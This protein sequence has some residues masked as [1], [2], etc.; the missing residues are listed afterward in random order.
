MS[1]VVMHLIQRDLKALETL[2]ADIDA[3]IRKA[4]CQQ[5]A[6]A[7]EEVEADAKYAVDLLTH[8]RD[9]S[10]EDLEVRAGYLVNDGMPTTGVLAYIQQAKQ[11]RAE[12]KAR[13]IAARKAA[14]KA[15]ETAK[16]V[17]AATGKHVDDGN[18]KLGAVAHF[19]GA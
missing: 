18:F 11:R 9:F 14:A 15:A 16:A 12:A 3:A 6:H 1:N 8:L 7:L 19:R 5:E 2:L 10:V 4:P 13:R 17:F